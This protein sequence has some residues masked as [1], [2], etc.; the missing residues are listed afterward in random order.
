LFSQKQTELL[1]R[2]PF[3][4]FDHGFKSHS[5]AY[6]QCRRVRGVGLKNVNIFPAYFSLNL[7]IDNCFVA[8]KAEDG[9]GWVFRELTDELELDDFLSV[10]RHVQESG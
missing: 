9:I 7:G 4:S 6:L 8:D 3:V 5:V 2:K 1:S 10:T